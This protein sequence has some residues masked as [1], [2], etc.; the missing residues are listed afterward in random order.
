MSNALFYLNENL[1][2]DIIH[3][4]DS[5]IQLVDPSTVEIST[6]LSKTSEKLA[7]P[8]VSAPSPVLPY[9][10]KVTSSV[11]PWDNYE[12]HPIE[13]DKEKVHTV[14]HCRREKISVRM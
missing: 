13:N 2:I 8:E 5:S 7:R 10:A 11:L 14:H 6:A 9:S 4:N 3:K 1:W 12:H